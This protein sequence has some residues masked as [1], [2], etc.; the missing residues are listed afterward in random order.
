VTGLT[1]EEL[2]SDTQPRQ[3]IFLLSTA[4][5]PALGALSP[6]VKWQGCEADHLPPTSASHTSW[7]CGQGQLYTFTLCTLKPCSFSSFIHIPIFLSYFYFWCTVL[8]NFQNNLLFFAFKH[9]PV[10]M[11]CETSISHPPATHILYHPQNTET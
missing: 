4:F 1:T 5:K 2:G 8:K 3:E 7:W 10:C 6:R 11:H 9:L